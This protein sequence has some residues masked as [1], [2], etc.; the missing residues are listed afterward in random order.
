M[1]SEKPPPQVQKLVKGEL[2]EFENL[3]NEA[4]P[5]Y[6]QDALDNFD[7]ENEY[8]ERRARARKFKKDFHDYKKRRKAAKMPHKGHRWWVRRI[9]GQLRQV[10]TATKSQNA[11]PHRHFKRIM[12]ETLIKVKQERLDEERNLK[13]DM[14]QRQNL[15]QEYGL[16]ERVIVNDVQVTEEAVRCL[17]DDA[18]R[19]LGGVLADAAFLVQH[20]RRQTVCVEDLQLACELTPQR[21]ALAKLTWNPMN[22]KIR[23][24]FLTRAK[25]RRYM[26]EYVQRR[27]RLALA[28]EVLKNPRPG[29][30]WTSNVLNQLKF[31]RRQ[32]GP[33]VGRKKVP[34]RQHLESRKPVTRRSHKGRSGK[35]R[36]LGRTTQEPAVGGSKR[37]TLTDAASTAATAE[38]ANES[39]AVQQTAV[40]ERG[41]SE[42][43]DLG[44]TREMEL[45]ET[46]MEMPPTP[47]G[48]EL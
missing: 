5:D 39:V 6:L 29:S 14:N 35:K 18:E 27:K 41:E 9:R 36:R 43:A 13:M 46:E 38:D 42:G 22:E 3:E 23:K 2:E 4:V 1:E 45:A 30:P 19:F 10:S 31:K 33:K 48:D 40:A 37:N 26:L 47:R 21:N 17:Q 15:P 12:K 11:I 20:G 7:V 8:Q 25:H 16:G 32:P 28:R 34:T 44:T 24:W